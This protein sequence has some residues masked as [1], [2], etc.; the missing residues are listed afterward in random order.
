[1]R[2]MYQGD[3]SRK[4]NLVDYGFR[5]P[6]ALDNRPLNFDEFNER[7]KQRVYVSATPGDYELE[8]CKFGSAIDD[9][10]KWSGYHIAE[11]IIRPTGLLDP[12]I[13]VRPA[14]GQIE[15]LYAEILDR[16]EK[17]ERV[18]VTAVTKKMSKDLSNYFA[19]RDLK[20]RYLHSDITT[21]ERVDIL[22]ELRSGKVDVLVGVNLLRKVSIYQ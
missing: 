1:M 6:S 3:R 15:D 22:H 20:V 21:L 10:R 12:E 18:L 9:G 17:D 5:L 7:I 8:Q 11:Q 13:D 16:I 2:G 4:M 19:N 14:E